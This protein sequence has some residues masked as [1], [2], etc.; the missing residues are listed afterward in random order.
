MNE[1][2][3]I[4]VSTAQSM[5]EKNIIKLVYLQMMQQMHLNKKITAISHI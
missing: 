2:I 5:E 4:F 1:W 3:I